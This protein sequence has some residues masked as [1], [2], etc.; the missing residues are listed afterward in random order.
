MTP[1]GQEWLDAHRSE[2]P[3]LHVVNQVS[4]LG[5]SS[6][7]APALTRRQT[8]QLRGIHTIIRDVACTRATFVFQSD[9]L[10]RMVVEEALSFLPTGE[11][12]RP[13]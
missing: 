3:L 12:A 9:R 4:D 13:L 10:I 11:L 2:F 5:F 1:K 8:A 7:L 6:F